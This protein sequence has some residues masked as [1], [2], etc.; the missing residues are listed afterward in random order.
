MTT[1]TNEHNFQFPPTNLLSAGNN[2]RWRS[3]KPTSGLT[4]LSD[5]SAQLTFNVNSS[6]A[7]MISSQAYLKCK[8]TLVDD[9]NANVGPNAYQHTQLGLAGLFSSD[10]ISLSDVEVTRTLDYPALL[11]K[12]YGG[13]TPATQGWKKMLEGFNTSDRFQKDGS[14]YLIHHPFN[15]LFATPQHIML[16]V[17]TGGLQLSFNVGTIQDLLPN[18]GT[19]AAPASGKVPTRV[20]LSD[21]SLNYP[22]LELDNAYI[23]QIISDL[24]G[25]GKMYY[26]MLD[27][28][29]YVTQGI[30]SDTQQIIINTKRPQSIQ[31]FNVVMRKPANIADK[32]RDRAGLSS[33]CDLSGFDVQAAGLNVSPRERPW[34]LDLTDNGSGTIKDPE[35]WY[36]QYLTAQGGY[37]SELNSVVPPLA[38]GIFSFGLNFSASAD[39]ANI[40][41][42][43]LDMRLS[44][45][46]FIINTKHRSEVPVNTR[47]ITTLAVDCV[48]CIEQNFISVLYVW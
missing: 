18:L 48:V 35:A 38:P 16:P 46:T 19:A 13:D 14:A 12:W 29:Q 3:V 10:A 2:I 20:L 30:A 17:I 7:A 34:A 26:S 24:R 4:L 28:Q 32:T 5:Q 47:I 37:S 22:E 43:G 11:S 44:D 45:G 25:G 15:A 39:Q 36:L 27:F 33:H 23:Q 40:F 6:S 21:I 41:G 1:L 8:M 9:S 42:D 31:S